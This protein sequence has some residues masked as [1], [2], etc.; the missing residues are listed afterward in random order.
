MKNILY[1]SLLILFACHHHDEN[2]VN[3]PKLVITGP[4]EGAVLKNGAEVSITGQVTDESLHEMSIQ[5]QLKSDNSVLF[6]STPEVHDKTSYNFKE[7][8]KPNFTNDTT[9]VYLAVEVFDHSD[10]KTMDTLNFTIAK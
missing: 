5:V 7:V 4:T 3:A 6:K 8:L 10:H 9:K 1:F 2:D